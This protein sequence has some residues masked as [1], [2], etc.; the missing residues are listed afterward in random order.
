M[1]MIRWLP[2]IVL[3]AAVAIGCGGESV[4]P[5]SPSPSLSP[6]SAQPLPVTVTGVVRDVLQRPIRDARIEVT[7]GASAGLAATS[8]ALGQF[9]ITAIVAGD[10]IAVIAS[11]DGDDRNPDW[12]RN[13]QAAPRRHSCEE[14]PTARSPRAYRQRSRKGRVVAE[15][16]CVS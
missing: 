12:Y 4:Q 13:L 14:R 15:D 8:D 1:P 5:T 11:K 3:V 2:A 9:S 7:E 10:R 6:T 16:R